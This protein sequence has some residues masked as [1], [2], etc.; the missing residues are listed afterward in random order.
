MSHA[1]LAVALLL[2]A[3]ALAGWLAL[4]APEGEG[5]PVY[6][7]VLAAGPIDDPRVSFETP[8]RNVRPGV[9]YVGDAECAKC[10]A[11]L[12]EAYRAHPMGRSAAL[13]GTEL[14]IE[15]FAGDEVRSGGL[16]LRATHDA[17]TV[18]GISGAS[19]TTPV[20][21]VIGSG[22]R[23]RSYL[24]LEADGSLWQSP[25]SWFSHSKRWDVSPGFDLADGMRRPIGAECLACHV[26]R[27]EPVPGAANR[28]RE[29]LLPLQA[30]VGCERCHGPG[31]LHVAGAGR[32][33]R[34]GA[35]D[36]SIVNPK[37]L[38]A[39]LRQGVC[40]QCHLQGQATVARPGLTMFDYRPG[41]PLERFKSVFVRHPDLADAQRSVGQFEQMRQSRCFTQSA[42]KLDCV[43]CH[44]P[45]R[46][47][48]GPADFNRRCATCHEPAACDAPAFVRASTRDDCVSCHMPKGDS[49]NI[50]H[51]SVTDHRVPRKPIAEPARPGLAPGAVP[52]VPYHPQTHPR[53]LGIALARLAHGLPPDA[54][55]T[56]RSL[57]RHAAERLAQ[58]R[59]AEAW[60]A[61]SLARSALGERDAAAEA[62]RNAR[63]LG[64]A[65]EE[66][67]ALFP[68]DA[69]ALDELVRLN[70]RSVE[71]RLGRAT[72]ALSRDACAEAAADAQAAA[73]IQPLHPQARLYAAVCRHRA[74]AAAEARRDADAV[75]ADYPARRADYARWY[76][77]RTR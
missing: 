1:R 18:T 31:E 38:E 41:L 19:Y 59:D 67:L 7:A 49:T 54:A 25:L 14:P 9:H 21:I 68:T 17:H 24:T 23:G 40:M 73:T 22:E 30:S 5:P 52:L 6:P 36:T 27:A 11:A 15:T 51:T 72:L 4:R 16:T 35:L 55:G 46:Q 66:I 44:D 48:S 39:D 28:F 56:R 61:L 71:H 8:F 37:H 75:G 69:A 63:S 47:A 45:H 13:I 60:A 12:A 10:H 43:S 20:S 58:P 3:G 26:D 29:P 57:A 53:D 70:P 76:R 34:M 33:P 74:G 62:A 64:P 2:V 50:A 77:E 65:S 42:G 32:G